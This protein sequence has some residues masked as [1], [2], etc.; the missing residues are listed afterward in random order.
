VADDRH[1]AHAEQRRAAVLRVVEDAK[2]VLEVG[3]SLTGLGQVRL[4][5]ADDEARDRLVELQQH[6][7]HETVA[8]GDVAGALDDVAALDIAHET[9]AGLLGEQGVRLGDD[10]VP[11]LGLLAD[12]E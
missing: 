2:D 3:A 4:E 6:V 7:A 8:H 10:L 9:D 5:K 11:L 12:V 1:S